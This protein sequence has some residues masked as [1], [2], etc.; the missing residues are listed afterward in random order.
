MNRESINFSNKG[1]NL[2]DLLV[3]AGEHSGDEHASVLVKKLLEKRPHLRIAAIGGEKLREAGTH[4]LFDLTVYSVVGFVEISKQYRPL[5]AIFNETLKWIQMH[6]P[7]SICFVDYPGFNLKMA[8]TLYALGLSSKSGGKIRL[9]YYIS[10][11]IWAW[12]A[13]RRFMMSKI[14]DGLAVIFPFEK[15][16]YEDTQLPVTYVGHPFVTEEFRQLFTY[17]W[18]SKNLLLLPGSRIGP[19]KRILPILLETF[20]LYLKYFS[21]DKAVIVYPNER[22]KELYKMIVEKFPELAGSVNL[23]SNQEPVTAK[24]AL[25]SSGTMSFKCLLAGLPGIIVYKAHPLTYCWAKLLVKVP[26]LGIGNILLNREVYPEFIQQKA[27]PKVLFKVLSEIVQSKE[28]KSEV[29]QA[30]FELREM[31]RKE[32]KSLVEWLL[33]FLA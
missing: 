10:P 19:I 2:V 31:L 3:I 23:Q 16:C 29:A 11:Q 28:K 22:I 20:S 7:R 8:K 30:A 4:F 14:L 27:E 26:Y 15:E 17:D 1:P 5:K 24:A 6:Q 9:L 21:E 12:K 32:D 33:T 25:S 13:K 18:E